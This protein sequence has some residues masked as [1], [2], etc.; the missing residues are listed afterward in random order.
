MTP[1]R[2]LIVFVFFAIPGFSFAQF[3][4]YRDTAL[5]RQGIHTTV[6]RWENYELCNMPSCPET[7][8]MP[9]PVMISVYSRCYDDSGNCIFQ[10]RLEHNERDTFFRQ[11][12]HGTYDGQNK[13]VYR[14]E[15]QFYFNRMV[16]GDDSPD[17][18]ERHTVDEEERRTPDLV[19]KKTVYRYPDKT[20]TYVDSMVTDAT[21]LYTV[22]YRQ[23]NGSWSKAYEWQQDFLGRPVYTRYDKSYPGH[24]D[25]EE[26]SYTYSAS[27]TTSITKIYYG[28]PPEQKLRSVVTSYSDKGKTFSCTSRDIKNGSAYPAIDTSFYDANGNPVLIT[29]YDEDSS[30]ISREERE[31]VDGKIARIRRYS[32]GSCEES[33][34]T[35]RTDSSGSTVECRTLSYKTNASP[36][37]RNQKGKLISVS[38]YDKNGN[39]IENKSLQDG[40]PTSK[41]FYSYS[42]KGC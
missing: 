12:E 26:T 5:A 23:S 8:I 25:I 37:T 29:W 13:L 32:N 41:S 22:L 24:T 31:Y 30:F 1:C 6:T 36:A 17:L 3:L 19:V 35:T 20:I 33:R 42:T 27:G 40:K 18:I 11:E 16:R 28:N 34:Y 14:T 10:E 39:L 15:H 21:G 7:K 4:A 2:N 38:R 9:K